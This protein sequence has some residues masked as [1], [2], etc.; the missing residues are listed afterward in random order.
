MS[1]TWEKNYVKEDIYFNN[2][3]INNTKTKVKKINATLLNEIFNLFL[4][5]LLL[6]SPAKLSKLK[7]LYFEDELQFTTRENI[8]I[9]NNINEINLETFDKND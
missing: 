3:N 5:Y 7:K 6:S 2:L 9:I 4:L 8:T 1:K